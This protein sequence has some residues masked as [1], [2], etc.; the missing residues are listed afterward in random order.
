MQLPTACL[1]SGLKT[2]KLTPGANP[3][4]HDFPNFTP[5]KILLFSYT[6]FFHKFLKNESY[7]TFTNICN[8]NL[9]D[10]TSFIKKLAQN[11]CEK[12]VPPNYIYELIES[13]IDCKLQ[14][15]VITYK[16]G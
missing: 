9:A 1:P 14:I 4:K 5:I 10:F 8:P 15:F 13:S 3:T 12:S 2:D 7:Q 6:Y 11:N 16:F